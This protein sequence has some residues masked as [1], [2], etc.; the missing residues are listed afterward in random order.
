M[1]LNNS[2]S[3]SSKTRIYSKEENFQ[4]LSDLKSYRLDNLS[5]FLIEYCKNGDK[6]KNVLTERRDY[7]IIARALLD[8]S[9]ISATKW[10]KYTHKLIKCGD[11]IQIYN[12]NE[13]K[14]KIN[15]NNEHIAKYKKVDY[16]K[17]NFSVKKKE[18][19]FKQIE[20][21]NLFRS[22]IELQRLVKANESSFKTFITLTFKDNITSLN[23]ANNKFKSFRTYIKKVKSDFQYVGVPEFQKRGAVHY[24][25]LTN[26][27]Y[28][29]FDLLSQEEKKIWKPKKKQWET[30]RILKKGFPYGFTSCKDINNIDNVVGYITKYL[31]KDID[32]R[33]WGH[34]RY[35]YS[36][37]NVRPVTEFLDLNN[38]NEFSY[39]IN[40]FDLSNKTYSNIYFDKL[41]QIINFDEFKESRVGAE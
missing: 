24:H 41:G 11:Y 25:L 8:N 37:N 33:L 18:N 4:L 10:K 12:Y 16:R 14:I 5:S 38:I 20:E 31:T 17:I 35:L 30:F 6:Y 32:N 34:R 40:N 1:D 23:D 36:Y 29:D 2:F 9:L 3:R 7:D 28:N 15:K 21:R 13:I 39:L 27:D 26:I 19:N 22:K